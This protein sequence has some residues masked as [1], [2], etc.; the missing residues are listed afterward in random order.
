M[1]P[2]TAPGLGDEGLFDEDDLFS[3][4]PPA[5]GANASASAASA[6][7][8]PAPSG[9]VDDFGDGADAFDAF[10]AAA[11]APSG[12]DLQPKNGYTASDF[13]FLDEE[14]APELKDWLNYAETRAD[15]RADRIR[16]F[17]FRII[18]AATA[19]VLI[20]IGAGVY[21]LVSG[22]GSSAAAASL[23]KVI[24]LQVSDT[25]GDSVGDV[26][27][28]PDSPSTQKQPGAKA[29][30]V[31]TD[32]AA[33]LI[34]PQ[35]VVNTTGFG[36]EPFSGNMTVS[37]PPGNTDDIASALGVTVSGVWNMNEVT[38]AGL[39]DE[40]GG[41]QITTTAAVPAATASPTAAAVSQ[42]AT[43][44]LNGQQA[45]SYA[46]ES[47]AGDTADNQ[48]TRF[49][50]VLAALFKAMPD[51]T[52]TINAYLNN[53][54]MVEDPALP[55]SVLAPA[56]AQLAAQDQ[57]GQL[58]VSPLPLLTDGSNELNYQ[59]A[60]PL[61]IGLL[62]NAFSAGIGANKLPRVLVQDASGHTGTQ[63]SVIRGTAQ[64][65][66]ADAGYTYLDGSTTT[67]RST[68]VIEIGSS[69]EQ[70]AADQIA[71]TLGLSTSEVQ[72]VSGLQSL[73]DVTVLLGAE[74]PGLAHVNLSAN[75]QPTGSASSSASPS[76]SRSGSSAS[77]SASGRG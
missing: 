17:R 60:T 24:L 52:Q 30:S 13:A 8:A 1:R 39:V 47:A 36:T 63:S 68:S 5:G 6:A 71:A 57:A 70:S 77:A 26:L 28:D 74:W 55:E 72:I 20:A 69:A 25:T 29:A 3:S 14:T 37:V 51:N 67:R 18:C 4:A 10:D 45:V 56:L 44:T 73:A 19:L 9:A 32:G 40:L 33:V 16:R 59:G 38:L 42:G 7:P 31:S 64:G 35:M 12:T 58:Q 66:L 75:P 34:P 11:S 54:G 61:V 2:A 27:L 48:A 23:N 43:T 21:V 15:S 49:G 53:L 65:K 50:Q 62:G 46:T 22:G 41:V 76:S